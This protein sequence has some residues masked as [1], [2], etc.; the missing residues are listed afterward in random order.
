MQKL[1]GYVVVTLDKD[2]QD[3]VA[4]L[5]VHSRVYS[6]HC[7]LAFKPD[8]VDLS[9]WEEGSLVELQVIGVASDDKGQAI[10]VSLPVYCNNESPHITV[11]CEGVSPVYSNELLKHGELKPCYLNILKGAIEIINF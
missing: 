2:S 11:S 4:A 3:A 6:H 7:T 10:L 9:K 5:A 8:K 1:N